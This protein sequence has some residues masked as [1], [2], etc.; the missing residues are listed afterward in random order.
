MPSTPHANTA[1]VIAVILDHLEGAS[2]APFRYAA[3]S[4][5]PR[6]DKVLTF[7]GSA[8]LQSS[9]RAELIPLSARLGSAAAASINKLRSV[10]WFAVKWLCMAT[11]LLGWQQHECRRS[12][13]HPPGTDTRRM[14]GDTGVQ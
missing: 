13:Q 1:D 9:D 11:Q 14:R 3:R 2:D 10:V 12:H 5:W 4:I 7:V 6:Q 8:S